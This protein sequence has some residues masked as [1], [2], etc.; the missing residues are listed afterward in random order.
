[1][2]Q[3]IKSSVS[4]H[5]G[6]PLRTNPRPE[7]IYFITIVIPVEWLNLHI[8]NFTSDSDNVPTLQDN[9]SD[10]TSSSES[11][12]DSEDSSEDGED[13]SESRASTNDFEGVANK[14]EGLIKGSSNSGEVKTIADMWNSED[15]AGVDDRESSPINSVSV[16]QNFKNCYLQKAAEQ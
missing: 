11:D 5:L 16:Y 1:M 12:S 3:G 2:H 8:N 7:V 10:A 14:E 15:I 13:S 4:N 6:R 9:H